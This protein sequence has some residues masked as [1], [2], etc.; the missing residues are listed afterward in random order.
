MLLRI[1]IPQPPP[2]TLAPQLREYL[3]LRH[4]ALLASPR[5][6]SRAA[7][8]AALA[9]RAE[10]EAALAASASWPLADLAA[11]AQQLAA[12][13]ELSA[14]EV[15][16]ASANLAALRAPGGPRHVWYGDPL[17]STPEQ[18]H[19]VQVRARAWVGAPTRAWARRRL[20]CQLL[21][22]SCPSTRVPLLA[23]YS[24]PTG[25][26]LQSYEAAEDLLADQQRQDWSLFE[27]AGQLVCRDVEGWQV[28]PPAGR[29]AGWLGWAGQGAGGLGGLGETS[30]RL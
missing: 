23:R 3:A 4:P 26:H 11:A 27:H 6:A 12:A 9:A 24:P 7:A 15:E 29:L 20:A 10:A 14:G 25:L 1:L 19:C 17:L 21:P 8:A 2:H 22:P 16:L 18:R 28:R 5:G 13:R 30:G